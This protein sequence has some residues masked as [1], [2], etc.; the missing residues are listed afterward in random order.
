MNPLLVVKFEEINTI[1]SEIKESPEWTRCC[2]ETTIGLTPED[3]NYAI[4]ERVFALIQND[5]S[6]LEE[7]I[8]SYTAS[9]DSRIQ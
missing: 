5:L 1:L 9:M 2:D 7:Q 6:Y 8:E 3:G 4:F